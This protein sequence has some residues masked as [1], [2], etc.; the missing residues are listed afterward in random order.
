MFNMDSGWYHSNFEL[1]VILAYM[2]LASFHV[3]MDSILFGSLDWSVGLG[4]RVDGWPFLP[5][6]T[7]SLRLND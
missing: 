7:G 1:Q 5:T 2:W 6:I 4:H 3:R